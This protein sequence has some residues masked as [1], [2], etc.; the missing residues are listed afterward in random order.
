MRVEEMGF[1][2]V[3]GSPLAG[4]LCLP[5]GEGPQ[6]AVLLLVGSGEVD[7]DSDHAKLRTGVTRVL[8]EALGN[9][10]VGSLRYDK[11]GVGA[12][13]GSFLETGFADARGDAAR[14]L[15]ALRAHPGVDGDRVVVIG[16]SEGAL[17]ALSLAAEDPDLAGVCLLAGPA[18]SGEAALRWQAVRIVATLPAPVRLLLRVLRQSP[19]R[20]QAKLFAKLRASDAPVLRIQ[21]RRSNAGWLRGFIDHDPAQEFRRVRVPLLAITGDL[22]LQVNPEDL[23]RMAALVPHERVETHRIA[24]VNHLL[25]YT[26]GTG[27]PTEYRKQLRRQQP[28]DSR[29]LDT[30]AAWVAGRVAEGD[31]R[32]GHRTAGDV[33]SGS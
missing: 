19:E 3:D 21:G 6:P 18:A 13:G 11:R 17:H 23:E 27:S 20:A 10:G 30:V 24:Q 26:E 22:D 16:H 2:A 8:A 12:S 29:V 15:E 1:A 32:S 33:A 5:P 14:A 9:V 4:T 31:V 28:L 25:R 7:R